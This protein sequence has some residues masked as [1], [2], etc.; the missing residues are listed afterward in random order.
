MI[1]RKTKGFFCIGLILRQQHEQ[2]L[3]MYIYM[4]AC[5]MAIFVEAQADYNVSSIRHYRFTRCAHYPNQSLGVTQG[6]RVR[7]HVIYVWINYW[8]WRCFTMIFRSIA[9]RH[10][11]LKTRSTPGPLVLG[12]LDILHF[13]QDRYLGD[14]HQKRRVIT[15]T[16]QPSFAH[17]DGRMVANVWYLIWYDIKYSAIHVNKLL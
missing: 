12:R 5:K 1:Y 14:I 4:N 3:Y 13:T 10:W 16:G 2:K 6:D 9:H 8:I 17:K 7:Q 15:H 11:S